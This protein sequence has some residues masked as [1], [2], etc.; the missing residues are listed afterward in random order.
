MRAAWPVAVGMAFGM[1][2][3]CLAVMVRTPDM[4]QR[5]TPA[6]ASE[7]SCMPIPEARVTPRLIRVE[8]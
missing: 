3:G 4:T 1:I 5:I 8:L 7:V 6:A 2:G